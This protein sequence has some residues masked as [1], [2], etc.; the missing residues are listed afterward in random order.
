MLVRGLASNE[1][2]LS[3]IKSATVFVPDASREEAGPA[4]AYLRFITS[5]RGSVISSMA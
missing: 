1:S 4:A 5:S 2:L 3:T